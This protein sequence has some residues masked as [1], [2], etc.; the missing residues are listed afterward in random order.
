MNSGSKF[1]IWNF[2]HIDSAI[3]AAIPYMSR[4]R[5]KIDHGR[6]LNFLGRG[7]VNRS[8]DLQF[9][10]QFQIGSEKNEL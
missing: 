4:V 5:E 10:I 2:P 8:F 1:C 6:N 7:E 9:R 3:F